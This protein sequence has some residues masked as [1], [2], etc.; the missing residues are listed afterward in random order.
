MVYFYYFNAQS[1]LGSK[2][3]AGRFD[4]EIDPEVDTPWQFISLRCNARHPRG[5]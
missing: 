1:H 5:G 3:G 4:V 2:V